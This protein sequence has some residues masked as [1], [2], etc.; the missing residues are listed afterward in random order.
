M[1]YVIIYSNWFITFFTGHF[2]FCI[3]L[4]AWGNLFLWTCG[5][6]LLPSSIMRHITVYSSISLGL[7]FV[8]FPTCSYRR[9]SGFCLIVL[10]FK[11]IDNGTFASRFSPLH[12]LCT[13]VLPFPWDY[14]CEPFSIGS[15]SLP[16]TYFLAIMDSNVHDLTYEMTIYVLKTSLSSPCNSGWA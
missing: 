12:V 1:L 6:W 2:H 7:S 14:G 8:F 5:A 10:I 16:R 13:S 4:D 15:P 9:R 3:I 11:G